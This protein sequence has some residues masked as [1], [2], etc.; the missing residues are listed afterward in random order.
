MAN[1]ESLES[2]TSSPP[3]E[4]SKS[5]TS[6]RLLR[7]VS[8]VFTSEIVVL[9]LG[10]LNTILA[11][12]ALGPSGRGQVVLAINVATMIHALIHMGLPWAVNY[13][14]A[15]DH[16]SAEAKSRTIGAL[17]R[18]FPLVVAAWLVANSVVYI[19]HGHAVFRGMTP[20]VLLL[21]A[22]LSIAMFVRSVQMSFLAGLHDFPNRNVLWIVMPA[23]V[24]VAL[25]AYM[26][27]GV[28]MTASLV[29]AFNAVGVVLTVAAGI[30]MLRLRHHVPFWSRAE[31]TVTKEYMRY[32]MQFYI[33]L[34]AQVMN[35][36]LDSLIVNALMGN[37]QLG[38]YATAVAGAEI[39]LLVPT[40]VNAVVYPTIA[41]SRGKARE[42]LATLAT[43]ATLYVVIG[44]ALIWAAILHWLIPLAFG[45]E[46]GDSVGPARLLLPG[47][48][49][50]AIVRVLCHAAAG[51]GHPEV[52][53]NTTVAGL[54]LTVPLD[55]LLI[56]LMGVSGASVAS[57]LAY[58]LSGAA[59]VVLY[60]RMAGLSMASVTTSILVEPW[61]L[62][63]EVVASRRRPRAV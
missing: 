5:P 47:M 60:A 25:V 28:R 50:L 44:L 54:L 34:L 3:S 58:S 41:S 29:L 33:G 42:R 17:W 48:A 9:A 56:P 16:G 40:A 22:I 59:A 51:F 10:V 26:A 15:R 13:Y 20:V 61:V 35:Y 55:F 27:A 37:A 46:F 11:T 18:L 36:R 52:L 2:G 23:V 43:G 39:L 19:L 14:V 7:N 45:P 38:I 12:R 53:T 57:S 63:R 6:K 32:G 21:T 24:A 4:P 31:R 1:I 30:A 62:A 49:A 8:G